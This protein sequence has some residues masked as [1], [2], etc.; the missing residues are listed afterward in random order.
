MS[1]R[2]TVRFETRS[3]GAAACS[4][5]PNRQCFGS[6]ACSPAGG[7]SRR[8][9]PSSRTPREPPPS[10]P[11]SAAC[12]E[13]PRS[14]RHPGQRRPALLVATAC[15]RVRRRPASEGWGH[16]CGSIP[17]RRL[18]PRPGGGGGAETGEDPSAAVWAVCSTAG[19]RM[20]GEAWHVRIPR[21]QARVRCGPP[22]QVRRGAHS[23][24][25][26]AGTFWIAPMNGSGDTCTG[27]AGSAGASRDDAAGILPV[28]RPPPL[29]AQA[30][31][32]SSRS[33]A[34]EKNVASAQP[35]TP[36]VLE[37]PQEP[38]MV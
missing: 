12:R 37:P 8:P 27:N 17:A 26:A 33:P 25:I 15:P 7:R 2:D 21:L 1:R 30:G 13:E 20:R 11:S 23:R 36:G 16:P 35:A 14:G 22:R 9:R 5:P 29:R 28:L 6:W 3:T 19:R 34:V 10:G 32:G 31:L 24:T 4:A 18:L 38:L